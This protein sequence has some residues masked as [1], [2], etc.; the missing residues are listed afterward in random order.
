MTIKQLIELSGLNFND[1]ETKAAFIR[2]FSCPNSFEDQKLNWKKSLWKELAYRFESNNASQQD[3]DVIRDSFVLSLRDNE[4]PEELKSLV[5]DCI[6]KYDFKKLNAVLT[7]Q[8]FCNVENSLELYDL[9][10]G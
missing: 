4:F 7:T 10:L 1:E 8:P 3:K 5:Q 9:I 6:N 2:I